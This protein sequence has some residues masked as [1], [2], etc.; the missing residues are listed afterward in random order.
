MS[1]LH[2]NTHVLLS[3]WEYQSDGLVH[4]KIKTSDL[5]EDQISNKKNKNQLS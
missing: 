2:P 1:R 5:K 4:N 3:H